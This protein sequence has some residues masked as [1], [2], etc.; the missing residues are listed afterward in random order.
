MREDQPLADHCD[1]VPCLHALEHFGLGRY[2]DPLD[3]DGHL[4]GF[5]NLRRILQEGG[6]CYLSVP[7][8][9]QR[10]EFDS[11]RVFWLGY[12]LRMVSDGFLERCSYVD[13]AGALEDV[14]LMPE[15]V[16]GDCGCTLGCVLELVKVR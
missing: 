12:L 3:R 4:R 7:M 13:D 16:G 14:T 9:P 15:L 6:T 10:T 2:G 8:G 5:R 11:E 1:S